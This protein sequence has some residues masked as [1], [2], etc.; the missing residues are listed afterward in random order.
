MEMICNGWNRVY[1]GE[2]NRRKDEKHIQNHTTR[3]VKPSL[4]ILNY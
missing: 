2:R 3:T 1:V 4:K